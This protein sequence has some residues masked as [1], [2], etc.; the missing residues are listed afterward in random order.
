MGT[1]Y[2][3]SVFNYTL[4]NTASHVNKSEKAFKEA[5]DTEMVCSF[6]CYILDAIW[7][8]SFWP[9]IYIWNKHTV[10][11]SMESW[12]FFHIFQAW[13]HTRSVTWRLLHR[14]TNSAS[15]SL[16]LESGEHKLVLEH[17]SFSASKHGAQMT[18]AFQC[19]TLTLTEPDKRRIDVLIF[20]T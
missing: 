10:T 12:T 2:S 20:Y 13:S 18:T 3:S 9:N 8:F 16:C 4:I 15:L 6:S 11:S 1:T 19:R 17:H 7:I 14:A 5:A